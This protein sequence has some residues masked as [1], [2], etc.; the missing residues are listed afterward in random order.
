MEAD[1]HNEGGLTEGLDQA[2]ESHRQEIDPGSPI[3]KRYGLKDA[4]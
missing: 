4:I 3:E 2:L 1:T